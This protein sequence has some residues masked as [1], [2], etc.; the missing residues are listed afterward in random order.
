MLHATEALH[1]LPITCN[2]SMSGGCLA[3]T[4]TSGLECSSNA[5]KVPEMRDSPIKRRRSRGKTPSMQENQV[6]SCRSQQPA[7]SLPRPQFLWFWSQPSLHQSP[8]RIK[9]V[10]ELPVGKRS[11]PPEAGQ[12]I[13][14]SVPCPNDWSALMV[15]N[16]P[17]T[18]SWHG[19]QRI[20]T[21][22]LVLGGTAFQSALVVLPTPC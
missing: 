20:S 18:G 10:F 3:C 19:Q 11:F 15:I 6:F 21:T 22:L 7:T 1:H 8:I 13:F 9:T 17:L 14:G 4:R 2:I 16:H 12:K 5:A